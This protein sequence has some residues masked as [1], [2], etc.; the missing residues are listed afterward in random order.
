[1]RLA[2]FGGDERMLGA[3]AAAK[4]A[5]WDALHISKETDVPRSREAIDAVMLPWPHSFREEKLVGGD[6][7]K[8][9]VLSLLPP[10]AVLLHGSG[11][12]EAP[13]QASRVIDPSLDEGFLRTNA[14]L[15]AEG[16]I[17]RAMGRE[18]RALLGGTCV[19]TGFGRIGQEL[20]RRLTAMEAF[21]IVCARNEGQMRRAHEMGAHPVPLHEVGAALRHADVIFNT[22]PSHV[23]GKAALDKIRRDAL[24]IELASLPYGMNIEMARHMGVQ[25]TV[26]GGLPGR[27]APHDAGAALFDALR[28][29]LESEKQGD[30]EGGNRNG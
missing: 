4:E 19:V 7:T 22:I 30:G 3:I 20:V 18:K 26:E 15:T 24:V 11:M 6:M 28:R 10:C 5:G 17:C 25:V 9:Q 1:M 29:A 8:E 2:V 13:L 21:V 16:A 23:L 27:Y 12:E 14:K